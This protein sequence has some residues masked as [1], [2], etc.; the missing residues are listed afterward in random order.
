MRVKS[1]TASIIAVSVTFAFLATGCSSSS[2]G[3]TS[4]KAAPAPALPASD[5]NAVP[6]AQ[7]KSGG[8]LRLAIGDYPSQYNFNQTD[9][10]TTS[11][12][13]IM[14][15]LMP[16][17]FLT[18]AT[19]TAYNDPAYV[20]GYQVTQASGAKPQVI[21]LHLNPQ[22]HWSDGTP[23]TANDYITQW[24]ATNGTN[25]AFDPSGTT[26]AN[27]IKSVTQGSSPYDV[28]YTFSTPFGE[29]ASLFGIIYPAKYNASPTEF[30]KGYLNAI[31]V[32]GGPF[33]LSAL[34]T[35]GQTVT[36]VR[37]PSFWWRP[38]KLDSIVFETLSNT[39]AV[40]ALANGEID[41]VEVTDVAQYDEV[42]NTPGIAAR[43]AISALWPALMFNAKDPLLTDSRVRD[44][45]QEA[46]NRPAIIS[47]QMKGLPV[48]TVPPLGNHVLL[49]SQVGYADDAGQYGQYSPANAEK[50]LTAAGWV[51]G[52]GGIRAKDGKQLAL[53]ILLQQGD[54]V[55]S[56]VGQ[57]L[58]VMYQQVGVKITLKTIDASDYFDDYVTKGNFQIGLWEWDDS[59]YPISGSEP[60]YQQPQGTNLFQNFGAIGSPQIDA[61]FTKALVTTNIEQSH[62]LADQ[63]DALIWQEGHSLPLFVE[64][65]IE[66]QKATL[67]NWGAFGLELPDYT[68]V[69]FTS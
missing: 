39:A 52:S 8:T 10:T 44:A 23:I 61:L 50:L 4:G 64:P 7:L 17:P 30:D 40:Q 42:K 3:H 49:P 65:D 1:T 29:W 54:T 36:V 53:T 16:T 48:P 43:K 57:L 35:S 51:P 37:D 22:A 34:N 47:S 69:G 32:T 60:V 62:K 45:L 66:M 5:T 38:A 68:E 46:V 13:A 25:T 11:I 55:G 33:K 19:G 14:S 15:A 63:A 2:S 24:Q 41:D 27:D 28:V 56:G 9:G 58:Q 12:S 20:S 26:G 6:Y 31:P 67:A 18:D 21:E 59:P